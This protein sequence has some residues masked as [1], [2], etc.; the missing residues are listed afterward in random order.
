MIF[1]LLALT[2]AALFTGASIYV[3]VVEHP[4]RLTLPDGPLLTEWKPAYQTA[5]YM[6]GG[7][8]IAAAVMG[9]LAFFFDWRWNWDWKWIIGGALIVANWPFTLYAIMPTNTKLMAA[10]PAN[11]GTEVRPLMVR[12][13]WLHAARTALG[14]LATLFFIA[15]PF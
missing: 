4:A 6:Q 8:A 14:A 9:L 5:T 1:G 7:L 13:G 10:D 12:W 2:L 15:A 11:P 3:S